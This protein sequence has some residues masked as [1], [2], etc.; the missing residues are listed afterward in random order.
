MNQI[1][2]CGGQNDRIADPAAEIAVAKKT[3]S[4]GLSNLQS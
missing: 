2:G 3:K 1:S 4:M